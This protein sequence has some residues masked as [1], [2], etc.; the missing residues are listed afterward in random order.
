[1][2]RAFVRRL[3]PGPAILLDTRAAQTG[4]P[5]SL[6]GFLP[7]QEFLD[8]ESLPA[9]C[10][11]E[12][13]QAPAHRRHHLGLAPD[14]PAFCPGSRKVGNGQRTAVRADDVLG[15]RTILLGHRSLSRN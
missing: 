12:R 15:P 7:G 3:K 2:I 9:A 11:F 5:V 1:M 4:R 6:D 8:S 14:H 13:Q 10:F